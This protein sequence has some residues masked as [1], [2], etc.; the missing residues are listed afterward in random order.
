MNRH[1]IIIWIFVYSVC[2]RIREIA[3]F[4]GWESMFGPWFDT[5]NANNYLDAYHLFKWLPLVILI[6][7]LVWITMKRRRLG[8]WVPSWGFICL[9]LMAWAAGQYL[10]LLLV[11]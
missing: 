2:D 6:A 5:Y 9:A 11:K 1:F 7:S 4:P 8:S 10:T 3:I